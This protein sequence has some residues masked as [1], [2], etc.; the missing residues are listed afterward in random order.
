[1]LPNAS[2]IARWMLRGEAGNLASRAR[3]GKAQSRSGWAMNLADV[4][5]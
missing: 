5:N 1:M 4:G 3:T 2:A